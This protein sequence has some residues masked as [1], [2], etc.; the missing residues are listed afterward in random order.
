MTESFLHYIWQ[1]QYFDRHDLSTTDGEVIRVF[2]PGIRNSNAGP[3]FS[4]ARIRIGELEW[5]GTVELHIKASGWSDHRHGDDAAYEN[6]VLH[7]VWEN[8]KPILRSDGSRMPTLELK[9]RVDQAMWN[10]YR[11]LF[12]SAESIPCASSWTTVTDLTKLSMLDKVLVLRL[13]IKARSVLTML[14]NNKGD[15][16]ETGYQLL[17]KNFGFKVNAEPFLRL[18]QSLPYRI[19]QKHTDRP[20]QVE[21]LLFGVAGFLDKVK[22]DEYSSLLVREYS[23]LGR[24]YNLERQQLHKSQWRFLRLRPANFPTVRLAQLAS[25]LSGRRNL[26][27]AFLGI[28]SSK[29]LLQLLDVQQ[30]EYWQHHYQFGKQAERVPA[31]GKASAQNIVINSIV[32]LLAAYSLAHDD[33]HYMDRAVELLQHIPAEKNI[34]TRQWTTLGYKVGSAF[35]SQALIELYNSFCQKRRCLECMVGSS[36]IRPK[37]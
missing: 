14:G 30:S 13:E 2:N 29:E 24:K 22:A 7:V 15:W 6:V 27:S 11:R 12:T 23:V 4:E 28:S 8:D 36:L 19:L 25:L 16:E 21:A 34:I 20:L 1:F 5:R 3:D 17:V 10:S 18:G 31:L 35:D 33:Q 32:P 26:I 9:D 37:K